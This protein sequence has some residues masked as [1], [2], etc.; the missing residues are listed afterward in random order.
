MEQTQIH[1]MKLFVTSQI[2]HFQQCHEDYK[3]IFILVWLDIY[4]KGVVTTVHSVLMKIT[5]YC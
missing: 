3:V 5:L 1:G 4:E 2:Q